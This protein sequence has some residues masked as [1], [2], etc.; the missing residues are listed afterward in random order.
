MTKD[1]ILDKKVVVVK[2][3][4]RFEEDFSHPTKFFIVNAFGD[5]VYFKT[6]SRATAQTW[7]DTLYGVGFYTVRTALKAS[8]S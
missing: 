1:E 8:V 4:D 5:A 3:S 7:A 2:E 6:R